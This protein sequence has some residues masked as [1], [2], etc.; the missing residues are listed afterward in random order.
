MS[1]HELVLVVRLRRGGSLSGRLATAHGTIEREFQG[2][3]EFLGAV[4]DARTAD[5]SPDYEQ[6]TAVSSQITEECE[7][8]RWIRTD[9]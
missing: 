7:E 4:T 2:W 8:P 5:E 1:E 9:R 3:I 6:A